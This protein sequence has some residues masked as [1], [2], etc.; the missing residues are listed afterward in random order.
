MPLA[1]RC[2]SNNNSISLRNPFHPNFVRDLDNRT[3]RLAVVACLS[4][5]WEA[6]PPKKSQSSFENP[7][8]ELAE[9]IPARP[10]LRRGAVNSQ[11]EQKAICSASQNLSRGVVRIVDNREIPERERRVH[12]N[13]EIPSKLTRENGL[14]GSFCSPPRSKQRAEPEDAT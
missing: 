13:C 9:G 10:R 3:L 11:P 8:K 7:D 6:H 2:S 5:A 1:T 4:L 14:Q 12:N